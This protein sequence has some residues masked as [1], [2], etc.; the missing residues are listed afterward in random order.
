MPK[1]PLTKKAKTTYCRRC[2]GTGETWDR[3]SAADG[4]DSSCDYCNGEGKVLV[5][6]KT[7][8]K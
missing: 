2:M 3:G 1:E 8:N 7:P 4:Y 5:K 6:T